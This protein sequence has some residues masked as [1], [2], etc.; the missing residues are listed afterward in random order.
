MGKLK[1][2]ALGAVAAAPFDPSGTALAVAVGSGA[3]LVTRS[4]WRKLTGNSDQSDAF[5][6]PETVGNLNK[7]D[8]ARLRHIV[9]SITASTIGLGVSGTL[10]VGLPYHIVPASINAGILSYYVRELHTLATK[11]G[12]K[13]ALVRMIKTHQLVADVAVATALKTVILI[14]FLGHDFGVM[15][16]SL[17]HSSE[18]ILAHMDTGVTPPVENLPHS[19]VAEWHTAFSQHG[20]LPL[21]QGLADAPPA[22]VQEA[23]IGTEAAAVWGSEAAHQLGPGG[24]LLVGTVIAGVEQGVRIAMED[25]SEKL[26]GRIQHSSRA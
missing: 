3:A 9:R 26:V 12:S 11:A 1:K 2:T 20:V 6:D 10:S 17:A 7:D 19:E 23:L 25:P 18:L 15:V 22:A 4:A 8:I 21:T 24:I 5:D 13:R 16:D 14:L